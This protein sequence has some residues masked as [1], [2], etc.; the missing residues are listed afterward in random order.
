MPGVTQKLSEQVNANK[1][2]PRWRSQHTGKHSTEP[3]GVTE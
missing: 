2:T 1:T 3:W